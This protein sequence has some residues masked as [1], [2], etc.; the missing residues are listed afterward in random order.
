M[1]ILLLNSVKMYEIYHVKV[2]QIKNRGS[3]QK[4]MD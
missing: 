2:I 4:I 1:Y 3:E